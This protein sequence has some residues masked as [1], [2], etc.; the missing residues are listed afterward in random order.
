MPGSFVGKVEMHFRELYACLASLFVKTLYYIVKFGVA[1]CVPEFLMEFVFP[2]LL[3]GSF[4]Y[5]NRRQVPQLCVLHFVPHSMSVS[6]CE[7]WK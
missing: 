7:T 5:E 4:P 6:A 1:F 2:F 3:Q